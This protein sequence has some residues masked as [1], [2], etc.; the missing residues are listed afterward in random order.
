MDEFR[1]IRAIARR[2]RPT[3]PDPRVLLGIGDD[4]AVLAPNGRVVATT[5]T[6]VHG[7]HFRF[8][9]MTPTAAGWRAVAVNLS[10]LAAMG[11]RP[12]ALLVAVEIPS[13]MADTDVLA[14]ASGI[15]AACREAG[16]TVTGGN[17]TLTTGPFAACITALGE[18]GD[19]W[20]PRSTALAGDG[21]WL[22][23]PVGSAA[24]GRAA[25]AADPDGAARRWPVLVRAYR[26][27]C[28]RLDL[29]PTLV[30]DPGVRGAID[31]S[32]GLLADLGHVLEASRVGAVLDLGL[33]PIHPQ[34]WRYALANREDAL[35]AALSGGDDYEL[36]AFGDVRAPAWRGGP[37]VRIGRI[38]RRR[39]LRLVHAGVE[40]PLPS[41]L[42]WM[43][44]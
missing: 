39:G 28:A 14:F 43:H 34:A 33:V 5:D 24:L 1:L 2:L 38:T 26:R 12:L 8:D 3:E 42:G 15:G 31:L 16:V 27:P 20:L 41:R 4:A 37:W 10:D 17:V 35:G 21:L 29:A 32:D 30:A 18:V 22:S 11:A 36:L 19:R 7:V 6:L 9:W 40:V 44:R 25:L 23:G 13:D